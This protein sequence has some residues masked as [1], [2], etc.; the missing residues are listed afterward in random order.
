MVDVG[1]ELASLPV[2]KKEDALERMDFDEDLYG[3]VTALFLEDTP[4]QMSILMQAFERRE[5]T[6]ATR[7]VHSIKSS[8]SNVGGLR[9][10]AIC[11]EMEKEGRRGQLDAMMTLIPR[12]ESELTALMERLR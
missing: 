5:L 9:L 11:W 8:A 10:A 12:L 7:Q 4:L 3:E 2:L 1:S 6:T